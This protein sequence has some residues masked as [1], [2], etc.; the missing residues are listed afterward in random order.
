MRL[1]PFQPLFGLCSVQRVENLLSARCAHNALQ[2]RQGGFFYAFYA[3]EL[4][5]K[6]CAQ[7][8]SDAWDIVEFRCRL[9]CRTLFPVKRYGEAMHLFLHGTKRSK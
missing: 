7:L 4:L 2:V 3:L 9:P 1:R 5:Q 8:R 6:R